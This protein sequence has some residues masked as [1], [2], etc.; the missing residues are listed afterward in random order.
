MMRSKQPTALQSETRELIAILEKRHQLS[1]A[2]EQMLAN[3]R[4]KLAAS[5]QSRKRSNSRKRAS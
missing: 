5:E 1:P 2:Q 4:H 3:L